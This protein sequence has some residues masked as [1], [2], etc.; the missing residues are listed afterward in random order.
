MALQGGN[1]VQRK[2][3]LTSFYMFIRWATVTKLDDTRALL[4]SYL[5]T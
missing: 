2:R 1:K 5:S 3:F 4:R